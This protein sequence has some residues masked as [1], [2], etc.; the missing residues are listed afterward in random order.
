[1][2]SLLAAC[3]SL[4]SA[5]QLSLG[6]CTTIDNAAKVRD[7]GGDY[8]ELSVSR[9]LV[10]E[11][12]DEEFAPNLALAQASPLPIYACNTF[13]PGNIR[14]TGPER[15][16]DRALA[17]CEV[18]FRRASQVGIR[19]L[20]LGSSGARNYPEG[21]D[22]ATAVNEFTDLLKRMGPVAEKYDVTVA[23]EPLNKNEANFMN[24][25]AEG[26]E[27][28]K[29]VGHENIRCLA[30]IHHMLM[31][32]EG[33]EVLIREKQ[34]ISHTHVA[35]HE[36]R[37]PPGVNGEDLTPYYNALKEAGYRSGMSIEAG[38]S[39]FDSQI[40]PAFANLKQH[41]Q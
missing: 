30:D 5:A 8:I 10:P 21:Y 12:S 34:Y 41:N 4:D 29:Q 7:A 23:L 31:E 15:D 1:L 32:S 36:G 16:H 24:T 19:Q 2:T 20:V 22:K 33:P 35:E 9:F 11:L 39:D 27:I 26:V 38:W 6:V 14:L 3:V 18:A 25:V 40:A 37:T 13:F 28:V 17:Y